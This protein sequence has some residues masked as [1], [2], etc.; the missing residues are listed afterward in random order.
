MKTRL[1]LLDSHLVGGGK[2]EET[3]IAI[4]VSTLIQ[5]FCGIVAGLLLLHRISFIPVMFLQSKV[6]FLFYISN[7]FIHRG[8]CSLF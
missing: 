2:S 1:L 8:S 7:A 3:R 4:K 6:S 5:S